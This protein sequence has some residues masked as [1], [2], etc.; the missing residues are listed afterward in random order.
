MRILNIPFSFL[1]IF[2]CWLIAQERDGWSQWRGPDRNGRSSLELPTP[3]NWATNPPTKLWTSME[4]PSQDNG[5]FSSVVSDDRFAYLSLVW[6]R[7]EPTKERIVNDIV[8][9]KMGARKVN[10]PKELVQKAE[11]DRM[12]LSPRLRGSKLDQWIDKWINE[13]LDQKQRMTQGSLIASRFKKG[14][15]AMSL[16]VIDKLFSIKDRVF[17]NQEA[18]DDWIAEQK[19]DQD[20]SEFISQGVPPTKRMADDVIVALDLRTGK[21]AWKTSLPSLPTGRSSSSTP[22]IS[23]GRIFAIGGTRIFSLDLKKGSL[24]WEKEIHEKGVASSPLIHDNLVIA[25]IGS[26]KA[27]DSKTGKLVWE[28]MDV[29]GKSGS[30]IFWKSSNGEFIVCNSGK[31]VCAIDPSTG[32]TLWEGPGGGSSTPVVQDDYLVVHGKQEE[33]G[34]IAFQSKPNGIFEKWRYP[35]LTRRTD[36][37]PLVFKNNVFLIGAGMR[38]CI[39]LETGDVLR[40][41]PAKHDISSPIMIGRHILCYEINGSFLQLLEA[42]P[43][44]LGDGQKFK[45]NALKCTTPSLIGSQLLIRQENGIAAFNL[46][47][48][49]PN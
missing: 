19:F 36:S 1:L 25:L 9:R 26:L 12:S 16:E 30:P 15:L 18:L 7:D 29:R 34:L 47:D 38:L 40:K 49:K 14:K 5:G 46:G 20:T 22:C 43:E 23:N 39:D 35:K 17:P 45:I 13:N 11:K 37:S 3:Q 10:L 21:F 2:P 27:F 41:I 31:T 33:T 32:K 28:N 44:K 6:H 42:D 48:F 4:L 8:L 24:I